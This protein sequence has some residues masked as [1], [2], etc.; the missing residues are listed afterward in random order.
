MRFNPNKSYAIPDPSGNQGHD[1][2]GN[3]YGNKITTL[4]SLD[5][6]SIGDVTILITKISGNNVTLSIR[7]KKSVP[8]TKLTP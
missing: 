4:K 5:G 6:I 8:I 7:A 3:D 2:T 1:P